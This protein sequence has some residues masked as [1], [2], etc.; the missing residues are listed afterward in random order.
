M[1]LH[2]TLYIPLSAGG[3]RAFPCCRA[4]SSPSRVRRLMDSSS[5]SATQAANMV[6]ICPKKA[7][8]LASSA[9]R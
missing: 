1:P 3:P 5:W 4:R 7:S 6:R 9:S 2:E 8:G